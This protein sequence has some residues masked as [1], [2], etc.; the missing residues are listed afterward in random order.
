MALPFKLSQWPAAFRLVGVPPLELLE[1]FLEEPSPVSGHRSWN[2]VDKDHPEADFNEKTK[3]A[4]FYWPWE[5]NAV[6]VD[7]NEVVVRPSR[8]PVVR[9]LFWHLRNEQKPRT[10]IYNDCGIAACCNIDHWHVA[11]AK[12]CAARTKVVVLTA[13]DSPDYRRER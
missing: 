10:V 2:G 5:G 4:V 12:E 8:Y 6:A 1:P 3:E 7:G 13:F 11:D 9:V